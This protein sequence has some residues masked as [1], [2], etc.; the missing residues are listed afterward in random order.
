ML[1][2]IRT[3]LRETISLYQ[4]NFSTIGSYVSWLLLPFAGFVAVQF[5]P[6]ENI[7]LLLGSILTLVELLV[8]IWLTIF[9]VRIFDQ[10]ADK[11]E[12]DYTAL[13]TTVWPTVYPLL[14]VGAIEFLTILGGFVLL[15][16]PGLV[17]AVWFTFSQISVILDGKRG[18]E[19]LSFSRS[20]VQGRFFEVAAYVLTG[21][22]VILLAYAGVTAAVILLA[23]GGSTELVAA[24]FNEDA[25]LW[26]VIFDTLLQIFITF[27]LIQIYGV[28]VYKTVKKLER[29][30]EKVTNTSNSDRLAA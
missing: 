25:P 3:L 7:S 21:P 28:L 2:L 20:L 9:L 26:Y 5:I 11:K 14:I 1:S 22:L 16:I 8:Y 24:F 30:E 23:T 17:F 4:S 27:P 15:I 6:D 29:T 18:I 10:L 13:Q 12:P 19:A